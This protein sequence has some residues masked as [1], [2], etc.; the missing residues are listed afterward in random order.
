MTRTELRLEALKLAVACA[1]VVAQQSVVETDAIEAL[2]DRYLAY[3]T[4]E[5]P[6]VEPAKQDDPIVA[7]RVGYFDADGNIFALDGTLLR[8]RT[9]MAFEEQERLRADL[10]ELSR[11]TSGW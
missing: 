2:A 5:E 3:I 6:K 9:P 11:K 8:W 4:R 7:Q 1:N 10:A